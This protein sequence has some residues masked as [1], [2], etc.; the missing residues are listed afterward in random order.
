MVPQLAKLTRE[1]YMLLVDRPQYMETT[2]SIILYENPWM[3]WWVRSDISLNQKVLLP[4]YSAMFAY[5]VW[6]KHQE[7]KEGSLVDDVLYCFGIYIIGCIAWTMM[8]YKEHRFTLHNFESIPEKF[9][10]KTIGNFFFTHHLH[11]MFANQEYRI[12][13]PLWHICKVIIP[14]YIV[15]YFLFGAVVALD[16]N[17]GLGLAQLF[18]DSMHFWFH[19][20][21]DFKIKFFQ[22]LKEKHMRHHY[23]D[24]TKDFGV[25]SSFWDYVFDT[26]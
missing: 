24:K 26:I 12:V 23:R 1:E 22:D 25:T 6:L 16:F 3:D 17:A 4:V 14:T 11:H 10:E 21:G 15:L 19:F 18:Y 5:S 2:D 8:E 9:D 20:G 13:I 7:N